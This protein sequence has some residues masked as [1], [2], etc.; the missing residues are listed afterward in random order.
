MLYEN[1]YDRFQDM[2]SIDSFKIKLK[3]GS[4]AFFKSFKDSDAD[5]M[6]EFRSKLATLYTTQAWFFQVS[7]KQEPFSKI[8]RSMNQTSVL[9]AFLETI[10]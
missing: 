8:K 9:V 10:L 2:A 5:E 1:F 6:L 3:N 4:E 7:R